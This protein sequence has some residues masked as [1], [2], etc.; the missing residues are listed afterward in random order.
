MLRKLNIAFWAKNTA[1]VA[2]LYLFIGL[3]G[4]FTAVHGQNC[5]ASDPTMSSINQ[6]DHYNWAQERDIKQLS[7]NLLLKIELLYD[8]YSVSDDHLANLHADLLFIG[9]L[10][11]YFSVKNYCYWNSLKWSRDDYYQSAKTYNREG[12]LRSFYHFVQG[13]FN[14]LDNAKA[15][16]LYAELSV[17]IAKSSPPNM[18]PMM[19]RGRL[20]VSLEKV[21]PETA[22][23]LGLK[24][25]KGI[26][27][28]Q[29]QTG[30]AA[31]K[32]GIKEGDIIVGLNGI[33]IN[34]PEFFRRQISSIKPGTMISMTVQRAG[35]EQRLEATVGGIVVEQTSAKMKVGDGE[36]F[37]FI[38]TVVNEK[39]E[40][41]AKAQVYGRDSRKDTGNPFSMNSG[42]VV[43]DV[44]GKAYL[45]FDRPGTYIFEVSHPDYQMA[46]KYIPTTRNEI[47]VSIKLKTKG[48]KTV[49][50]ALTA[51]DN[52]RAVEGARIYLTGKSFSENFSATT[53][54]AGNATIPI[55]EGNIFEVEIFHSQFKTYIT[56]L[57][58]NNEQ[59]QYSL[60]HQ[61]KRKS[62]DG[63]EKEVEEERMLTVAVFG[64]DESG[65]TSPVANAKVT[66]KAGLSK[67]TDSYGKVE[68]TG[69]F[70][71]GEKM[72][73]K[74]EKD[75]YKSF[76]TPFTVSETDRLNTIQVVLEAISQ[77]AE[78]FLGTW[79]GMNNRLVYT[80]QNDDNTL[81][82]SYRVDLPGTY[83]ANGKGS[84][85][86]SNCTV[87]KSSPECPSCDEE[88]ARCKWTGSYQAD[89]FPLT[90][91]T[92]IAKV[93]RKGKTLVVGFY[94]LD[95][96]GKE[97]FL[98]K[99]DLERPKY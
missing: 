31:E 8:C 73:V 3:A 89:N 46:D 28:T 40:P 18:L 80:F 79:L 34:E 83:Y 97:N 24:Q 1:I 6:A 51:Q 30:S 29:V 33:E 53:D 98:D 47:P 9:E 42:T 12:L 86:L 72:E 68:I 14:C 69:K 75:G 45:L 58:L 78:G 49:N 43:T 35:R 5:F 95:Q 15:K 44:Y 38:V 22:S 26:L 61:L 67:N 41:V 2:G 96:N 62:G 92:G 39:N 20:G 65:N 21:T 90:N 4:H 48:R 57:R 23:G 87:K 60:I 37:Q 76:S 10:K 70:A 52:G 88:E 94:T 74:I 50:V 19:Q 93:Y 99:H 91:Y 27:V 17:P 7:E 36:K 11:P 66:L 81:S 63:D 82:G 32:A 84:G 71:F 16:T 56:T 13:W 77:N 64:R 59:T 85:N 55:T 54:G 25:A